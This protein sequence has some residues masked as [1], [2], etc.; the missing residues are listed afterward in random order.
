MDALPDTLDAQFTLSIVYRSIDGCQCVAIK[1]LVSMQTIPKPALY[2]HNEEG[3]GERTEIGSDEITITLGCCGTRMRAS[4]QAI[5]SVRHTTNP[6]DLEYYN[7]EIGEGN[8]NVETCSS[9][10]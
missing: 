4:H 7:E 8:E 10:K 1:Y 9:K 5:A 6:R 2:L 3:D